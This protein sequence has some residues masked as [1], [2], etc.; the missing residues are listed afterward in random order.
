MDQESDTLAE[1][2]RIPVASVLLGSPLCLKPDSRSF[3]STRV[4]YIH[5]SLRQR[6]PLK[7]FPNF[8]TL[9]QTHL[10]A[11]HEYPW[12]RNF[13]SK[14][15]NAHCT[16]HS[17]IDLQTLSGSRCPVECN[18]SSSSTTA[19]RSG[20]PRFQQLRLRV[21]ASMG[22]GLESR[23]LCQAWLSGLCHWVVVSSSREHLKTYV[24]YNA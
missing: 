24:G 21:H 11:P 4:R 12:R 20:N 18:K 16:L 22:F 19:V 17:L 3:I 9:F 14:K 1:N 6:P 7:S 8:L 23:S 13:V 2:P 15:K 10:P 5:I